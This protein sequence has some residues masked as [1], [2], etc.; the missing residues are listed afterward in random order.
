MQRDPTVYLKQS[1]FVSKHYYFL[2]YVITTVIITTKSTFFSYIVDSVYDLSVKCGSYKAIV[3]RVVDL[4]P[5]IG[6]LA[7]QRQDAYCTGGAASSQ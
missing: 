2:T 5:I 7:W 4:G 3:G 1:D 6:V